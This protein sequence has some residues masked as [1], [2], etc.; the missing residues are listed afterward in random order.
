MI[1]VIINTITQIRD[2]TSNTTQG[3][4]WFEG[5]KQHSY[6]FENE[7][8]KIIIKTMLNT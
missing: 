3:Q 4:K 7:N 6:K 8:R 1:K 2:K 5:W